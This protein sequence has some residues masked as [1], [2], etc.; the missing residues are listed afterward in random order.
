MLRF[1]NGESILFCSCRVDP[2]LKH[3]SIYLGFL[4]FR[5]IARSMSTLPSYET[6][7]LSQP[8]SHVTLVE[9]NRTTKLNAMDKKLFEFVA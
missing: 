6:L 3:V 8:K 5:S 7:K 9:L 4:S 2:Q 1:N